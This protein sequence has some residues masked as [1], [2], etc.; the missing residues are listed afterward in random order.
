MALLLAPFIAALLAG[1]A[2]SLGFWL[3]ASSRET[4]PLMHE[5][6]GRTL[7]ALA[8][9]TAGLIFHLPRARS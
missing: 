1:L 4:F 9:A 5:L 3:A 2:Y 8:C 7:D 6:W